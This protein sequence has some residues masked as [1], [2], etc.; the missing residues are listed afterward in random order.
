MEHMPLGRSADKPEDPF[1]DIENPIV[2]MNTEGNYDPTNEAN[3]KGTFKTRS[4]AITE[5]AEGSPGPD[6]PI[7]RPGGNNMVNDFG[8]YQPISSSMQ[9]AKE[10]SDTYQ[11]FDTYGKIIKGDKDQLEQYGV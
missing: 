1:D 4:E 2:Q 9:Y 8:S 6:G 3:Q 7:T 5:Q 11:G 10:G